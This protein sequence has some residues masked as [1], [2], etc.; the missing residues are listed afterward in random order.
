MFGSQ[1]LDTG[2]GL[3][4]LFA[5]M[6]LIATS[7]NEA[8]ETIVKARAKQLE[9]GIR[10]ILDDPHGTEGIAEKFFNNPVISILYDGVYDTGKLVT[11]ELRSTAALNVTGTGNL[12][13]VALNDAVKDR[14][15]DRSAR[16]LKFDGV[17]PSYVPKANFALAVL[18]MASQNG[19]PTIANIRASLGQNGTSPLKNTKLGPLILQALDAADNDLKSAQQY[20]ESW[21]DASMERVTGWYKRRTQGILFVIGLAAAII[22]NVDA[23]QVGRSLM[24]DTSMRQAVVAHAA[25]LKGDAAADIDMA[26]KAIDAI[27]LPIGWTDTP[28]FAHGPKLSCVSVGC[29]NDWAWVSIASSM[30]LGWLITALAIMLG[31]PF[32]FDLLSKLM[33]LRSTVK[34]D[35]K[36]KK[37]K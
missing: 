28:Q 12:K 8:I 23:I 13:T 5:F 4:L 14:L 22:L 2:I 10:N 7:L 24:S 33:Q 15:K 9:Q 1:V 32:W 25:N 35:D 16:A 19:A 37:T 27:G 18:Q 3:A 26:K 6:S 34:T 21:Y 30:A 29:L 11:D 31:A 17:I 20:L 36:N